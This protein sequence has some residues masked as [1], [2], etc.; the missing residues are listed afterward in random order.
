MRRVVLTL[1][2]A[3]AAGFTAACGGGDVVVVAQLEGAQASTE[4]SDAV[5][6]GSMEVRLF[7]FDRD[8][9][10]DSLARGYPEP[11]PEIP[12]SI[13]DL[14]QRVIDT[15]REWQ[16]ANN[17]WAEVRD[18]LQSLSDTLRTMDQSSGEYFAL[19][20]EFGD[21]ESEV[22]DLEDRADEA[23]EEFDVL[24][25]RLNQQSQEIRL[26]RQ[27]WADEAFL[28]VDSIFEARTEMSGREVQ[29]DTTGAEGIA[30]FQNVAEGEWYVVARYDRQFDELY[31][32]LPVTVQGGDEPTQ[33]RLSEE[34]AEVR[35]KL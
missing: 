21:L 24:L 13:Y 35:Q 30:R 18:R 31:W 11:E 29:Y 4:E 20:Q 7:P 27:N 17:R 5:A 16:T 32:N 25:K 34:N 8:V 14:Q 15:Q 23:F 2:A 3:V 26:A 33:V 12:D 28:D 9:V 19:F 22:N 10:F 6:L 1:A